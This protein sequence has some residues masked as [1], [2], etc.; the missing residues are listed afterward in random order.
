MREKLRLSD[1][2]ILFICLSDEWSFTERRCLADIDYFRNIGGTCFL[3]C[4]EKSLLDF[5]AEKEDVPRLYFQG[6]LNGWRSKLNFY[7]QLQHILQKQ[8]IDLIHSYNYNS[9]QPTGLILRSLT[10]IPLVFTFNEN[11]PWMRHHFLNRWLISRTDTILTFSQN[12]KDLAEE[13]FPVTK[14]KIHL[15]GAGLD[16]S[17]KS[18]KLDQKKGPQ[19]IIIFVSKTERDLKHLKIFVESITPLFHKLHAINFKKDLI[20]TFVTD[21]PWY[22]HLIYDELKRMILVRQLE[23]HFSFETKNLCPAIFSD[24]DI[25][26]GLPC[27][28]LFSDLDLY[29]LVTKTPALLPRTSTRQ[30]LIKQG[31]FGETYHPED[32]RELRDQLYKI[33]T[34]YSSYLARLSE[35]GTELVELHNFDLYLEILSQ[36]YEKLYT[37]RL[38]Y[39]QKQKRLA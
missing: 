10:H 36:H 37:Q 39:T 19:K 35:A 3:L 20:F 16:L 15:T 22:G 33:L 1:L 27:R 8:Q 17:L 4:H 21:V 14:R 34:N 28:E 5:E 18:I 12:I 7:F 23:M 11:V 38:R 32:G 2:S 25:F 13:V 31:S 24:S 9:L 30:Q 6:D 29:A 26:I